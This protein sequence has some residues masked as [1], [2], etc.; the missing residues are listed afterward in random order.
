[1]N[2]RIQKLAEQAT[3]YADTLDVADSKI[4][5][6]IRD[7]EFALL[8]VQDCIDIISPYTIRM[9]RPGEEYLH[10][11]QEIKR[12]FDIDSDD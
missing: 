5:Q 8:I 6:K 12:H 11:I 1:M 4:Y 2:E 3:S 9:G 7:R 10:P